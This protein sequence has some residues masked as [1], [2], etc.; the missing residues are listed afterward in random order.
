V[1]GSPAY[2]ARHLPPQTPLD[3]LS[4]NCLRLRHRANGRR[5]PCSNRSATS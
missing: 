1:C 5:T 4:H 3:L 2:L